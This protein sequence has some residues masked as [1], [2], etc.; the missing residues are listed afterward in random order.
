MDVSG[1]VVKRIIYTSEGESE[2]SGCQ[3]SDSDM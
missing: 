3:V 1:M 2:F